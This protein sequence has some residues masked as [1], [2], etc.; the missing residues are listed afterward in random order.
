VSALLKVIAPGFFTTVQDSGRRGYLH[1]GVPVSGALDRDGFM[2]A[3]ALV[4]NDLNAANLEM[5][6]SGP[7]FEVMASSVRIALVGGNGTIEVAGREEAIRCDRSVRLTKGETVRVRLSSDSFCSYLAVEGGF[8]I[9][10]CLGSRSTYTR[11]PGFGGFSGRQLRAGDILEGPNEEAAAR[12][13][14]MLNAPRKPRFDQ[15][16]RVVLGPQDDY[17]TKEA[18]QQFL[19]ATYKITPASDRIGFRLE[20]PLLEHSG[21]YNLVSDGIVTGS[22]QVPGSKLP[23]ILLSDAQTTGGYPKIATVISADLPTVGIRR[24]GREVR[25]Q[26]VS[27]DEAE[28]IRRSEHAELMSM[29]EAIR[30]LDGLQGLNLE[31]L[32]GQN[33]VD[34]VIDGANY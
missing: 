26:Q 7:E 33:L 22:I 6:G 5:I 24:A 21:D 14:V 17:F 3:N 31:A 11:A 2:L 28:Q 27:R 1:A 34:G 13:E 9:P 15:P 32:Y 20:G 19:S 8:D 25:F 4:G 18:V 29:I 16:I 12:S 23:I 30:P 10:L